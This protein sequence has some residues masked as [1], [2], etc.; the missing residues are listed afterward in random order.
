MLSVYQQVIG[1]DFERVELL[2]W[3]QAVH[4]YDLIISNPPFSAALTCLRP[5]VAAGGIV[6]FLLPAQ[7]DQETE[8][9]KGRERLNYLD[10]LR[11]PDG[12]ESYGKYSIEGRIDFRGNGSTDRI[13]YAW[14]VFGRGHEGVHRR[15]PVLTKVTAE[16]GALCR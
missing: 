3:L 8:A 10:S 9:K 14:Y 4:P 5:A 15:V 13:C 11:L 7:W 2:D 6:A 16:Q 1:L 12:R